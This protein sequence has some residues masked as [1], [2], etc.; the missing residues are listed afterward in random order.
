MLAG[1]IVFAVMWRRR[2]SQGWD[3]QA[4]F[5]SLPEEGDARPA[6]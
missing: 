1:S 4:I 5:E 2:Q 6:L 3:L